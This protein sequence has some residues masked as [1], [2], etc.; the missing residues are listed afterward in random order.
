MIPKPTRSQ[1]FRLKAFATFYFLF[2]K[3]FSS[4]I[5]PSRTIIFPTLSKMNDYFSSFKSQTECLFHR[6]LQRS[7]YL[8]QL[9]H[10]VIVSRFPALFSSQCL[11]FQKLAGLFMFPCLSFLLPEN[12]SSTN[13]DFILQFTA[14]FPAPGRMCLAHC[15]CWTRTFE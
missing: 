6:D 1:I 3:S 13:S 15:R 4:T 2:L 14:V 7:F 11:I 8:K 12:M 5:T 9:S 10:P